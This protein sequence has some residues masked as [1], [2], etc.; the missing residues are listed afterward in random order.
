MIKAKYLVIGGI[1]VFL[2]LLKRQKDKEQTQNEEKLKA[3]L[4]ANELSATETTDMIRLKLDLF[5]QEVSPSMQENDRT[6]LVVNLTSGLK[7]FKKQH[8]L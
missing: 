4:S 5:F 8:N 6:N 3:S 2:Y 1:V 7:E